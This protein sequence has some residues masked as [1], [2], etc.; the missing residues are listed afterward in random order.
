MVYNPKLQKWEGND[1]MMLDFEKKLQ[2]KPQSRPA[3]ITNISGCKTSQ[4][5]GEMIFDPV[6]MCW[7]GNEQEVVDVFGESDEPQVFA[8]TKGLSHQ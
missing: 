4:R 6:K 1:E 8:S 5:V 2:V 7:I 3:L